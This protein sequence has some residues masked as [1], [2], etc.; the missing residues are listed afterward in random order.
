MFGGIRVDIDANNNQVQ[1]Y[2]NDT[3]EWDGTT[4]KKITSALTPPAREN[5]GFAVDPIRNQL[6][7]FGGYSGFY[8]SDLWNFANGQWSQVIEVLNRRRA[9]H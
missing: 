6:V 4:W 2:A 1:V 3:W 8:H 9:A 7:M 5:G